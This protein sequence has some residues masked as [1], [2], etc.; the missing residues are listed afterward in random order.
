MLISL[1][2]VRDVEHRRSSSRSQRSLTWLKLD[3]DV[4]IRPHPKQKG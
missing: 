4:V 3:T 2:R 1:D